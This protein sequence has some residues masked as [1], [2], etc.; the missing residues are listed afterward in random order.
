MRVL[1]I[2]DRKIPMLHAP[3]R[4]VLCFTG[5]GNSTGILRFSS[6]CCAD[7]LVGEVVT[8]E[9]LEDK[10]TVAQGERPCGQKSEGGALQGKKYA[11]CF[12]DRGR[13]IEAGGLP[14]GA[15]CFARNAGL[16]HALR[17]LVQSYEYCS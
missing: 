17:E 5:D 14:G 3:G 13:S 12:K 16:W 9:R 6:L 15:V 4:L 8:K 10:I 2:L 7:S 11:V 1:F